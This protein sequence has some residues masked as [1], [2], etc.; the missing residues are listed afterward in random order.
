MSSCVE[1]SS[2]ELCRA[3]SSCV[4]GWATAT[5]GK[6]GGYVRTGTGCPSISNRLLMSLYTHFHT[7]SYGECGAATAPTP[8]PA[9]AAAALTTTRGTSL[10]PFSTTP[11]GGAAAHRPCARGAGGG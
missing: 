3:E 4:G 6:G 8:P 10:P 7:V 11:L 2:V 9:T 1:L 5:G